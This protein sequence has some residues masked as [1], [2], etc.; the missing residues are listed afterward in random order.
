MRQFFLLG[1]LTLLFPFALSAQNITVSGKVLDASSNE[2]LI[3]VTVVQTG[4]QNGTITDIDGNYTI[5]CPGDASLTFSYIGYVT[6]TVYVN[7]KSDLPVYL[8]TDDKTLDEIVVVGY[9]TQRKSDLTGSVASVAEDDLKNRSTTDAGAALQG[10]VSGVQ[11]LN[12]SGAP[13]EGAHIRVRGYSS[14]SGSIGPLLIVDGLKVDNIQYLDP[15]MIQSMEVLKDA[16]SAAIYGAQAGNGVILIT[17]KNGSKGNAQITYE[18][19][20]INQRLGKK[21]ELFEG[22]EYVEYQRAIGQM[23]DEIWDAL[24]YKNGEYYN[25]FDAVFE[26]SWAQQHSITMQG[27][28]D[29]GHFLTSLNYVWNDGIVKGGKDTYLRITGQVNADYNIKSWLSVQTNNSI[30]KWSRKSVSSA[31]YGSLLNSVMS[32]D[33]LTPAYY[34][35]VD[36]LESGQRSQL[37]AGANVPRDPSHN[38]DFYAVSKYLTEATG[39]PLYQ[40]D[41]TDATNGGYTLRGMSAFNLKPID[42][43]VITSRFGYRLSQSSSHNYTKP[44]Y[45]TGMAN[46]TKYNIS[47]NVNTGFYYQFENFV[48]YNKTFAQKHNVGVMIGMSYEENSS[49]NASISSEEVDILQGY[50]RNFQY[51]HYLKSDAPK[52]VDNNPGYNAN[53]AY[54]GR[55]TYS[56]DNRYSA[57]FNFRADA[58]DS[59]KLSKDA[60]WGKFP[61]FSLGWTISNES[62]IKDN[63]STDVLSFLKVRGSWGR[64][65]NINVLSGYPYAT[66]IAL[67][68]D[69]YQ[70]D[71]D[72]A[73]NVGF[74]S[75]PEGLAN[76]D[77]KWETSEQIDLGLDAR[78]LNNRLT[79]GFDY[80]KKT[81]KDLLIQNKPLPEV[82]VKN[83]WINA[84]KVENKGLEF[85]VGWKDQLGDF[86][87]SINAN[88]STLKNE[89]KEMP[90]TMDHLEGTGGGVSGLNYK[91]HTRFEEGRPIWYFYGYK[92]ARINEA[93]GKPIYVTGNGQSVTDAPTDNDRQY[94]GSAIPDATYG[95]T[96]N[97]EYKGFDFTMFGTGSIHNKIFSLLYS[98]DRSRTNCLKL[99]YE[100]SW[101]PERKNAKYANSAIVAGDWTYWSSDVSVFDGSYFKFKQIQLG[102][103][104]PKHIS[105]KAL[106]SNCRL[107]VSLDDFFTITKY[108]GCDPETATTTNQKD[109][110]YD[111]GTYPTTKK[112]IFGVSVT[113]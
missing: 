45:L 24:G 18:G 23:T 67:K 107:Y 99:Y 82:G 49:D 104:I 91:V 30:E 84:G 8:N 89:V 69:W 106:I 88:L 39:N 51:I 61:S 56:Y 20:F 110:G 59:S 80:F 70:F 75:R 22:A 77:L 81:T 108:P 111:A 64:N 68:A 63:I 102:Y 14:N 28:N 7:G 105:E 15:S 10:K 100:D 58:F 55:L 35:S 113:F 73:K 44:Y 12:Q 97:L 71:P 27:G 79:F 40:R 109:M 83:A 98:A 4:T 54:F 72:N 76:P 36:Q 94:I 60:R 9:G 3:G 19:K 92:L 65:G 21:A 101:T 48:N 46:S 25:W 5:S 50:E 62:F 74:G 53:M 41:K 1:L 93:D 32:L 2:P 112:V 29:K 34:T 95:L 33:P 47:A 57:Q 6:Q 85:E 26:P 103:T 96:L 31:S 42:G 16:A 66:S 87:Y 37:E 13:G 86:Q 43:L 38:N 52:T 17:T 90:A 78:F 11:I